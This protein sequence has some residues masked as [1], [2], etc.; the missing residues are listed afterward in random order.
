MEPMPGRG[1]VPRDRTRRAYA[2]LAVRA[3]NPHDGTGLAVVELPLRDEPVDADARTGRLLAR[4]EH[5][6]QRRLQFW[7]QLRDLR[8]ERRHER[9]V[10][11]AVRGSSPGELIPV[12]GERERVDV[13]RVRVRGDD[14]EVAAD[15]AQD[16][17]RGTRARVLDDE[18]ASSLG[19]R[20]VVDLERSAVLHAVRREDVQDVLDGEVLLRDVRG[21]HAGV[22]KLLD[23]ADELT[24]EAD[25]SFLVQLQAFKR[26]G[27]VAHDSLR[28]G[29]G[30]GERAQR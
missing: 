29:T 16:V 4:D 10:P 6:R 1:E 18:I 20:H 2:R 19:V 7:F 9:D 26:S 30:G 28:K 8:E 5:A 13:P 3:V 14:V 21:P 25:E 12:H 23:L 15:E 22:L 11:E 27:R 17:L 24:K